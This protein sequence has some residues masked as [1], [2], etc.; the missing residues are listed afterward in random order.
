MSNLITPESIEKLTAKVI[1]EDMNDALEI[2]TQRVIAQM[3]D[4]VRANVAAR[5]IA[6]VRSD[7]NIRYDQRELLIR[8][9]FRGT[10]NENS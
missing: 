7:Y 6:L 1:Q 8:V 4:T 9:K 10:E 3:E 5:M 2:I